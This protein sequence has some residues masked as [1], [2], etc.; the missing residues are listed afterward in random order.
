MVAGFDFASINN[1]SMSLTLTCERSKS[2]GFISRVCCFTVVSNR[3][4][5]YL[6]ICFSSPTIV[7]FWG[8]RMCTSLANFYLDQLRMYV[9]MG[10]PVDTLIDTI[11]CAKMAGANDVDIRCH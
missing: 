4:V 11:Q 8:M 1:F 3:I 10:K 9:S 2:I 6:S 7:H 5:L